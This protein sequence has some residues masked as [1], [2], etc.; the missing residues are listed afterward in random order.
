M[1]RILKTLL[2]LALL[3]G[4]SL[5]GA[6]ALILQENPAVKAAT[7]PTAED[8]AATRALVRDLRRAADAGPDQQDMLT[9]DV[10][11]LNSALRLGARFVPGFRGRVRLRDAVLVA[12]TSVPVPWIGGR[13]WLNVTVTV[14][15]FEGALRL[16]RVSAGGVALP[17]GLVLTGARIGGNLLLGNGFGDTVVAAASAMQI[18][19]R[20]L[21]FR[22][23]LDDVGG[24][25]VMRSAFGALRSAEMPP[26]EEIEAYH[27]KIRDAMD[28][29]TLP[30]RGSYLPYIRFALAAALENATPETLPNAYTAAIFGLAKACGSKDFAMIAGRVAQPEAQPEVQSGSQ[31]EIQSDTQPTRPWQ[32]NCDRMSLNGRHDSRLHFTLSAA[33]QAASNRGFAVSVGEFK[34][35]YDTISGSGGF[36][37]TDMAANLSGIALSNTMMATSARDWPAT[38]ARIETERDVIVSFKGLPGK[39]PQAQFKARFGD[40]ESPAYKEMIAQIEARIAGIGL[41]QRQ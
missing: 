29:G 36:D 27:R 8:V 5:L 38:L 15:E 34:E 39:I 12:R 20:E 13:K 35:L 22:I 24:N 11:Q 37:F 19:G 2:V 10:A 30:T 6:G 21:A 1:F 14:P 16:G 17:P 9:T 41:Y 26:P 31:S 7:P 40:V 18:D 25:G 23:A 4:V 3:C 28:A 32:T 33:L